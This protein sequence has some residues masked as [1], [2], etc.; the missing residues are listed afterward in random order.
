MH[1]REALRLIA[2][3]ATIPVLAGLDA[4]RLW[5]V[6]EGTHTRARRGAARALN[7]HQ[8]ETVAVISELI[9]PRTDTPGARDAGV[10][11]FVDLLVAEWYFE[12]E[13]GSFIQGLSAIDARSVAAGGAPFIQL[14]S[15]GQ[16]AVMQALDGAENPAPASAE[17]AFATIKRLTVYGYFTSKA[18]ATTLVI[19]NIWPG[20]Y[21]GC[22]PA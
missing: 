12:P 7:A 13:R 21:D 20:R 8:L 5:A 4:D 10:P 11:E 1:R 9:I 2:G 15:A 3:A 6:A 14:D 17:S 18:V 22:I 16:Q 19:P